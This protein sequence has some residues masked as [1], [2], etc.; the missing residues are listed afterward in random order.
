[1]KCESDSS[2]SLFLRVSIEK[3][4]VFECVFNY[5]LCIFRQRTH[6]LS[7]MLQSVDKLFLSQ[8]CAR[9]MFIVEQDEGDE[10][11]AN[12]EW[13]IS[14][15]DK[16]CSQSGDTYYSLNT[17]NRNETRSRRSYICVKMKM[18]KQ[19]PGLPVCQASSLAP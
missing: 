4:L 19:F 14:Y 10:L 9:K 15:L 16:T 8:F 13:Q 6:A 2:Q 12:S 5:F 7:A 17:D 1:M 11:Q 3:H 18:A